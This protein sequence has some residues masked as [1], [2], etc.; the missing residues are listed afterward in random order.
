MTY[1]I[2]REEIVGKFRN[3]SVLKAIAGYCFYD[4]DA[5]ETDRQYLTYIATHILNEDELKRKF[6]V[7]QGDA[8]M[9]NEEHSH[10]LN[11]KNN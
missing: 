2:N 10:K 6:V 1:G 9:L 8:E 3:Y 4:V 5:S 11:N 7:V